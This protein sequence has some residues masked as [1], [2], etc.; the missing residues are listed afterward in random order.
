MASVHYCIS[1]SQS[2]LG[3]TNSLW[4]F[5]TYISHVHVLPGG[6]DG[7]FAQK[8]L[9]ITDDILT[10]YKNQGIAYVYLDIYELVLRPL[11]KILLQ[12]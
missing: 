1:L 8:T 10:T 9:E 2:Y 7:L 4:G 6:S 12:Y 11:F 3:L 5:E